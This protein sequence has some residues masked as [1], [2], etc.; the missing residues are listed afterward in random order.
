MKTTNKINTKHKM[1][2][3]WKQIVTAKHGNKYELAKLKKNT[4][5]NNKQQMKANNEIKHE[6]KTWN[7]QM[8]LTK[9]SKN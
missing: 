2:S 1:N 9:N 7:K 3:T 8:K 6:N 4:K 5:I